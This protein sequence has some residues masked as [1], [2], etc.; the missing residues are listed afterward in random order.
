MV[1]LIVNNK[2]AIGVAKVVSDL[3][4][5]GYEVFIPFSDK[6]IRIAFQSV[7]K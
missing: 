6:L 4:T 1:N 2:G 3:T 5:K 7:Y